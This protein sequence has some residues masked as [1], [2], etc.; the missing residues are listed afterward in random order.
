MVYFEIYFKINFHYFREFFILYRKI[1]IIFI[2]GTLPIDDESKA[3]LILCILA[4]SLFFQSTR[5]PFIS[6]KLNQFENHSIFL[7]LMTIYLGFIN[8]VSNDEMF[9]QFFTIFFMFYNICFYL[10][11]IFIIWIKDLI[12]KTKFYGIIT[13]LFENFNKISTYF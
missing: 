11:W 1:L 9:L 10:Y 13:R 5:K 12:E 4:F 3:L 2:A 7:I 8:S 6:K